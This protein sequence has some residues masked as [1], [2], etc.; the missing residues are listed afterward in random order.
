MNDAKEKKAVVP[1]FIVVLHTL[2][3]KGNFDTYSSAL[4]VFETYYEAVGFAF[5]YV[6]DEAQSVLVDGSSVRCS[7]LYDLEGGEG[8]GFDYEY[9]LK[10]KDNLTL[11]K[12]CIY[13]YD[14]R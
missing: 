9:T 5:S 14:N 4:E 12:G 1:N 7:G 8:V 6:T 3:D 2:D 10:E 13:I 11:T